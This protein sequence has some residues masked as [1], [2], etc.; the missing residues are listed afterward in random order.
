M[1]WVFYTLRGIS[2]AELRLV[3]AEIFGLHDT[4]LFWFFL[5]DCPGAYTFTTDIFALG[6][7]VTL[8]T[9]EGQLN[10]GLLLWIK[11][12]LFLLPVVDIP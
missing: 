7:L 11:L 10:L 5:Y 9:L 8:S 6:C 12:K 3:H 1:P 2:E 4:C